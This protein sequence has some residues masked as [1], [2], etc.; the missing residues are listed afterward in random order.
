MAS[1]HDDFILGDWHVSPKLNR[2]QRGDERVTIKNKSMAVLV[3]LVDAAGEVVTRHE[4]LDAVWPGM[5]VTDDVL[6]QSIVELRKAFDDD[7]K[8]P[9][10]IETIPRV[11][12]RL[13]AAIDDVQERRS[14][15][16]PLQVAI[17]VV[18][19]SVV[20]WVAFELI[21]TARDPVIIVQD[22]PSIAV[23]PFVNMSDDPNNEYF[24]DGL[25]EE[26][27]NLLWKI[28]GL[29]VIGRSSSNQFKGMNADLRVIGQALG[30]KTVLEGSV[31][32]S[33]D[34]V[35]IAAQLIDVVDGTQ[36]WADS[37][38]RTMTDISHIFAVQDNVAAAIID[39]L[40]I[41]V[42]S[43]PTR[44]S[45]TENAE[46]YSLFLKAGAAVNIYDLRHAEELLIEAIALD[47]EYAEAWELLAFVYW[48]NPPGTT[49]LESQN[50]MSETAAR[51][52]ALDPG[53]VLART[54]YDVATPRS[55]MRWRTIDGF[56]RAAR[57]RPDD[58]E[59]LAG[60]TFLLAEFGYLEDAVAVAERLHELD[61]LSELANIYWPLALYA[62]GRRE[63][64]MAALKFANQSEFSPQLDRWAVEGL[65]LVENQD[66]IAIMHVES[67]LKQNDYPDPTWFRKL[68][69]NG[70]DPATG[71]AYLDHH[72][73]II[74]TDLAELDDID[75]H[76]GL[77][78]L[79][80]YFGYLDRYY[81]LVLDTEP[82][83]DL[84]HPA[85]AHLW[86]S[87]IFHRLGSTANPKYVE[88]AKRMGVVEIWEQRGAPDFCEKV[89]EEWTCG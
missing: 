70:R 34:Q 87:A 83:A 10:I 59:I 48:A 37:Y 82:V 17:A 68:V 78:S 50:R 58:P 65:N 31:R 44:G 42:T 22:S 45:P 15:G 23:L 66:E 51:A 36:M 1:W 75:W 57:I 52:I 69:T 26:I 81:E 12:F 73:P 55:D 9:E 64:A 63:D 61:P 79:Y 46:A 85:G 2:V 32:M 29:D 24:S 28:D 18:A 30:V 54:Y 60:F 89:E 56:E 6:T 4:I 84:W 77:T 7:A 47:P 21:G 40:Q 5:E 53:L 27:R 43:N 33:G 74:V 62:V 3:F 39:A 13:V 14:P 19:A 72:I 35:R 86:R 8:H 71:E 80:M 20:A 88:L 49:I 38:D 11:G 67:W 16:R 41:H 25:S 76:Q